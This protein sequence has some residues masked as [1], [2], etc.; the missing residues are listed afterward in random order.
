MEALV[1]SDTKSN[2]RIAKN[3]LYM[4]I[5]MLAVLCITFY[6]TRVIL[7]SLGV[8]DYGVYNVVAGFVSLFSFLGT[9]M[10]NA[11]QRFYNYEFAR[12]GIR[13]AQNVFNTSVIIQIFL[14]VV[15]ISLLELTGP[16]Y[17]Q[18]KMVITES[19]QD[20]AQ[21][22]FQFSVL[23]FV[24]VILQSPF[25][26]AVMAHERMGF[27]SIVSVIDASLKL[28]IA[29]LLSY[30][31]KQPL[32]IYGLFL[33]IEH[34]LILFLYIIYTVKIFEEI[35]FTFSF[36]KSLMKTMLSFS[37]WNVFGTFS[38]VMKDQGVNMIMNLFFGPVVN[39]A[40][41]VASQINNG[42]Q[43]FVSNIIIP[44]RPHLVQSY[45]LGNIDRVMQLTYTV[46]K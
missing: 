18:N 24:C 25:L 9:S 34:L 28:L 36:D 20:N 21:Y 2:I 43:S 40:K 11:I 35:K 6:S 41:G 14:A 30:F 42:I 12:N 29:F 17:I 4:T 23:S 31:T 44:A 13:G 3:S 10:S 22:L 46:S 16:W 38:G 8:V 33:F 32:L 39:A 26:A 5:R 15:L 37:G 1:S 45:S 7:N 27:Y 19:T